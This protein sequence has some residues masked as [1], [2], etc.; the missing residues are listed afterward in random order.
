MEDHRLFFQSANV[1]YIGSLKKAALEYQFSGSS[2]APPSPSFTAFRAVVTLS[3]ETASY[4]GR[5]DPIFCCG[6]LSNYYSRQ[7]TLA[8]HFIRYTRAS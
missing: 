2:L 3:T 6:L 8:G 5:I 1:F 7:Y 4:Q